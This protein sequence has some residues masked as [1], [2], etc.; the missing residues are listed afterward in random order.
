MLKEKKLN[1]FYKNYFKVY[2]LLTED[3][4]EKNKIGYDKNS[5]FNYIIIENNK[6]KENKSSFI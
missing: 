5:I 3:I 1:K 4:Y 2:K 6:Q